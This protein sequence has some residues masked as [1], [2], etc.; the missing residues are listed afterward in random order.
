MKIV[1]KQP[2]AF[3]QN[4]VKSYT[5]GVYADTPANRKL[6][7]VG[8]S[9]SQYK[10]K[11][12]VAP[13]EKTWDTMDSFYKKGTD[14]KKLWEFWDKFQKT[15]DYSHISSMRK[16]FE[17]KFPQVATW[18][19]TAPNTGKA[20][21]T[22]LDKDGKEIAKLDLSGK[23]VQLYDL[24]NFMDDCHKGIGVDKKENSLIVKNLVKK[25]TTLKNAEGKRLD[26]IIKYSNSAKEEGVEGIK[27]ADNATD[28]EK[29]IAIAKFY[30]DSANG[31]AE[32]LDS[33]IEDALS[34]S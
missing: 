17:K 9:Y 28:E 10:E 3:L 29:R 14:E 22:A 25:T 33:I 2:G 5:E 32:D 8:M 4:L 20:K 31:E 7:R 19:Q 11:I 24:Q 18:K 27:V 6:G 23:Y 15:G 13:K 34:E 21:I 1:N 16:I 12:E 30:Y 26:A